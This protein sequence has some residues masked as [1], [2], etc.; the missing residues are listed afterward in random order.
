MDIRE[1]VRGRWEQGRALGAANPLAVDVGIALL[2][3]AAVTMPFVVPRPAD[4]EPATWPAYG[5]TTLSVIP[6]IWRR[7]A[8]LAVLLANL[9][10]GGLYRLAL[11][12][13]GQPLPYTGLVIVYTVA[14][15]SPPWK[16]LVT[17]GWCWSPCPCRCGSTPGRRAS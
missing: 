11:E 6:L 5:L 8:P 10:A 9:A 3:Q 14:A 13:P 16:R 1:T 12:G 17:G 2:A 15:L 7:R 4:L